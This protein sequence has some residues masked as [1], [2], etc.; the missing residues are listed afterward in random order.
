MR[1]FLLAGVLVCLAV[2]CNRM[3]AYGQ[4]MFVDKP[5]VKITGFSFS[6]LSGGVIIIRAAIDN[7]K[8]SL[9]FILDTGS[10]G[11]SL[12]SATVA[13]LGLERTPSDKTIRGIAGIK[14]VDFA[15]NHVLHFPGL[16]VDSL[17]FH[18]NDYS[19]L[20]SIYGLRIDGI[21]GFSLLNRYIFK[22]N[23]DNFT[24]EIWTIGDTKY[25]RGGQVLTPAFSGLPMQYLEIEDASKRLGRYYLDTGAG[26]CLLLSKDYAS[27]SAIFS[28]RRRK[29]ITIAEG[30][31]GKTEMELS[32]IKSMQFGN[33]RF[34]NVPT[35]VFDDEFNVTQYPFL[36]GL[37][38]ND[39][40]RRFNMILNYPQRQIHILP[41]THFREPFDY[42]YTGLNLFAEPEG[43]YIADV[44]P[45]SPADKAGLKNDDLLVSVAND[46]SGNLQTYKELLQDAGGIIK[47]IV[48]RNAELLEYFIKVENIKR[49]RK[50]WQF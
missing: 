34:R 49:K 29:F 46:L 15:Y 23:Y 25:P 20:S 42:A 24:I 19:L 37:V 8:D 22:I 2:W 6:M 7:K 40:M 32:V 50:R 26:L 35:Y 43:I 10:G 12:D 38:G 4:E 3:P 9:N 27:D 48:S 17:D 13:K 21:A 39:L 11:I 31:G 41:N 1:K 5:S 14:Q 18:I 36:A 47:V 16:M 33:Y 44:V 30:L 45:G 28:A